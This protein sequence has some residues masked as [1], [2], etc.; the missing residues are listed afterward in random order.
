MSTNPM[1]DEG[2]FAKLQDKTLALMHS[3]YT[4]AIDRVC[5]ANGIEDRFDY[6]LPREAMINELKRME[7]WLDEHDLDHDGDDPELGRAPEYPIELQT[8]VPESWATKAAGIIWREQ[9]KLMAEL[10]AESRGPD[11]HKKT[12]TTIAR[13]IQYIHDTALPKQRN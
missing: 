5:E 9:S 6:L 1:P 2:K 7:T 11:F 4:H 8:L 10:G 3:S 13:L 12:V